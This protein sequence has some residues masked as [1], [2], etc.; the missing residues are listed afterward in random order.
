MQNFP[1]LD[2]VYRF[3]CSSLN[4][5]LICIIL[6]AFEHRE[7]SQDNSHFKNVKLFSGLGGTYNEYFRGWIWL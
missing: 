6:G 4:T 2:W 1:I 3:Y 5:C 7:D